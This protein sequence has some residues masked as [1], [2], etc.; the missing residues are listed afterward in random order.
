MT[1]ATLDPDLVEF[2]KAL[3]RANAARDIERARSGFVP[4]SHNP[5]PARR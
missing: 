3:A 2:V 5:N 1:T 4:G